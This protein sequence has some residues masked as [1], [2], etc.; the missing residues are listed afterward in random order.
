MQEEI[1]RLL[2]EANVPSFN[3]GDT[4]DRVKWMISAYSSMKKINQEY[5]KITGYV[6]VPN[7]TG[8]IIEIRI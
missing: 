6:L 7:K 8:D 5:V 3:N 4:L 1:D 2:N